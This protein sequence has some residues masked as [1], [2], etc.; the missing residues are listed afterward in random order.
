MALVAA[1]RV[2]GV[3]SDAGVCGDNGGGVLATASAAHGL[4]WAG[5]VGGDADRAG[6]AGFAG[7]AAPAGIPPSSAASPFTVSALIL[8][9]SLFGIVLFAT[10]ASAGPVGETVAT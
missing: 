9:G 2:G 8:R 5:A 6:G 3:G 1:R 10:V 4:G 7:A